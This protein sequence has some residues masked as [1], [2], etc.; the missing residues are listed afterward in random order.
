L[1]LAGC[2]RHFLLLFS[3]VACETS[4]RTYTTTAPHTLSGID[5]NIDLTSQL[6]RLPGVSVSGQGQNA[7]IVVRGIST[8]N[9]GIEP[10]F[11]V[12]GQQINGDYANLY[13]AINPRDIKTID[14]LTNP[15]D[16]GIYGTRGANGVIFIRTKE[17]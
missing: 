5:P 1:S 17:R 12:D 16:T 3:F 9:A 4:T 10:L 2:E 7:V 13:D 15:G 14:L 8:I 11:V 6:Q